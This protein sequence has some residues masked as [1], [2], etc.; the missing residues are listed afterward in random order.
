MVEELFSDLT[1]REKNLLKVI[2]K[3][4][5]KT[6]DAVSSLLLDRKGYFEVSSATIRNDLVSLTEKGYLKKIHSFSGRVPT[7]K[8]FR[9]YIFSQ[10]E[11]ENKNLQRI[12]ERVERKIN[13]FISSFSRKDLGEELVEFISNECQSYGFCYL[14]EKNETVQKGFKYLIK[15]IPELKEEQ[16][17]KQLGS[18]LDNLSE[19]LRDIQLKNEIEIYIG[20]ENPFIKIEPMA[21]VLTQVKDNILGIMGS[22]RMPYERNITFIRV[23][24]D[25]MINK[26]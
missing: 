1:N 17:L 25:F 19:F 9:F 4:Y 22:K 3:E 7:D 14:F 18:L 21:M 12:K 16:E 24:R 20:E 2:L 8:A 10:I 5:Y 6:D 11:E 15:E 13:D 23:I 26:I